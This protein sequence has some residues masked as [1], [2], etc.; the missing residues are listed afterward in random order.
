[1]GNAG[2]WTKR[3]AAILVTAAL[4]P[5]PALAFDDGLGRRLVE[6]YGI[7]ATARFS[8]EASDLAGAVGALCAAPGP[9]T[10][11]TAREAF[12][13]AATAY[14]GVAFLRFGPLV[15][16]NRGDRVLFFPDVR[17]IGLRQIQALLADPAAAALT[18]PDMARKSAALQGLPALEFALFGSDADVLASAAGVARCAVAAAIAGN[19]A[20]LAG[21]IAAAWT[22]G[23]AFADDIAGPT[24]GNAL[25][26][27]EEE[28][29]REALKAFVAGLAFVHDAGLGAALGADAGAAQP[30]RAPL[31]RSGATF[32]FLAAEMDGLLAFYEAAD[33]AAG[34]PNGQVWI[35][36]ALRFELRQA[37]ITLRRV[38]LSPEAAFTDPAARA[39]LAYVQIALTSLQANA[40][41][42]AG[43]LGLGAG[44]SIE[45]GGD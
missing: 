20:T 13:R 26:R 45:E 22:P 34:L 9:A 41:L 6:D 14:G 1:M 39:A 5:S 29:A 33:L 16:A 8:A 36:G 25:Y 31:W 12:G 11:G 10:L 17:G 32:P 18:A 19:L 40:A 37:V 23:A 15:D 43:A 35:D 30:R 24:P 3:I 44:F 7:P 38:T 2:R 27:S 28:V 42:L 21:E 4:L